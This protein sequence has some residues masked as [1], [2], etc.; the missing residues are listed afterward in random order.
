MALR[1]AAEW[2]LENIVIVPAERRRGLANQLLEVL[3]AA[4]RSTNSESLFLEVRESNLAA[5]SLY[6]KAGFQL[7]GSRKSYYSNP[8]EDAV[9]YHLRLT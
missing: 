4:A 2:E 8:P 3:V 1:I 7:T 6:E 9:L 5:R